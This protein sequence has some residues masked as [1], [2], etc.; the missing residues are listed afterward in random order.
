MWFC[1]TEVRSGRVSRSRRFDKMTSW[2]M[3]EWCM[4]YFESSCPN[5]FASKN[6]TLTLHSANQTNKAAP[7]QRH[8]LPPGS[9][10]AVQRFQLSKSFNSGHCH[11]PYQDPWRTLLCICVYIRYVYIAANLNCCQHLRGISSKSRNHFWWSPVWADQIRNSIK[12]F[13][14]R[15]TLR[16]RRCHL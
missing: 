5:S 9:K 12:W 8:R 1:C 16:L 6:C 2:L 10:R 11:S 3:K 4:L 15:R 7:W 13:A 14:W